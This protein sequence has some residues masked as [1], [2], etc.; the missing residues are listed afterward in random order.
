MYIRIVLL[1]LS[2]LIFRLPFIPGWNVIIVGL[3]AQKTRRISYPPTFRV[4]SRGSGLSWAI[5]AK[6]IWTYDGNNLAALGDVALVCTTQ[7]CMYISIYTSLR[8]KC[9]YTSRDTGYWMRISR[10]GWGEWRGEDSREDF[11][12][13]IQGGCCP[14]VRTR[15]S[16]AWVRSCRARGFGWGVE[17]ELSRNKSR[18]EREMWPN[19]I[20]HTDILSY[21]CIICIHIDIYSWLFFQSTR[22]EEFVNTFVFIYTHIYLYWW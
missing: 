22:H 17:G 11:V 3:M 18:D 8:Y 14:S 7:C 12:F 21:I 20:S 5:C 4:R 19:R 16:R 13:R 9:V 6:S 1:N 10:G 2:R 15:P